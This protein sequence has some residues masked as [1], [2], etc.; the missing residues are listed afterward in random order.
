MDHFVFKSNRPI[1]V[2]FDMERITCEH[3][4]PVQ[5]FTGNAPLLLQV[6]IAMKNSFM[7]CSG[8]KLHHNIET[9]FHDITNLHCDGLFHHCPCP[10][11]MFICHCPLVDL[12]RKFIVEKVLGRCVVPNCS[13]FRI[14]TCIVLKIS[15]LI[16]ISY[17]GSDYIDLLHSNVKN[18]K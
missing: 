1:H 18:G 3:F 11:C 16:P 7:R 10:K 15:L 14:V 9:V 17:W 4:Q 8:H 2:P 6:L 13:E 12:D 5:A